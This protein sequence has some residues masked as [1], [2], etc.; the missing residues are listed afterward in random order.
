MF[1]SFQLELHELS[2]HVILAYLFLWGLYVVLYRRIDSISLTLTFALFASLVMHT[3]TPYLYSIASNGG[4]TIGI[5]LWYLTFCF[6]NIILIFSVRKAH[7]IFKLKMD[8]L[9]V[10]IPACFLVATFIQLGR[11]FDR[12]LFNTGFIADLYVY[13]IQIVNL[14]LIVV[15]ALCI[16]RGK[17]IT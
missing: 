13:G 16:F 17:H 8:K 12:L 4:N 9:A 11:L 1:S 14:L 15:F 7:G 6:I 5:A 2:K 10:A 3:L